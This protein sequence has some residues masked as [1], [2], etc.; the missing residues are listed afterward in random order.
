MSF[1]TLFT[2]RDLS[3]RVFHY[4][5]EM[6][7]ADEGKRRLTKL[8]LNALWGKL[9]L[10]TLSTFQEQAVFYIDVVSLYPQM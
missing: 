3:K 2:H 9:T 4:K 6:L 5:K 10:S 1:N 8:F 7:R